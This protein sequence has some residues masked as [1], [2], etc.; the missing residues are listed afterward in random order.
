MA[1][2]PPIEQ[3]FK[4]Q[5]AGLADSVGKAIGGMRTGGIVPQKPFPAQ[6]NTVHPSVQR[7]SP[8]EKFPLSLTRG[9]HLRKP[10][11]AVHGKHQEGGIVQVCLPYRRAF[12]PRCVD[13]FTAGFHPVRE[14]TVLPLTCQNK[15]DAGLQRFRAHQISAVFRHIAEIPHPEGI[16]ISHAVRGKEYCAVRRSLF[17]A[18]QQFSGKLSQ[19]FEFFTHIGTSLSCGKRPATV[20]PA[21]RPAFSSQINFLHRIEE[22]AFSGQGFPAV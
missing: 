10:Q 20:M 3:G 16:V 9:F 5:P 17:A 7:F 22:N 21:G 12:C 4:E 18:F 15:F 6:G 14:P 8:A 11:I 13:R 1:A 19:L 2:G